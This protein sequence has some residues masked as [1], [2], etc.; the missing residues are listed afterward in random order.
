MKWLKELVKV[1]QMMSNLAISHVYNVLA[2][3]FSFFVP[4][5]W[6]KAC[7]HPLSH[8]LFSIHNYTIY[9][10]IYFLFVTGPLLILEDMVVQC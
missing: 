7:M 2:N 10:L 1:K 4:N 9:K 6:N 3:C 8:P 5:K